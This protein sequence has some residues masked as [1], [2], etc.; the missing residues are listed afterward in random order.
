MKNEMI[1]VVPR[2]TL[3]DFINFRGYKQSVEVSPEFWKTAFQF[4]PRSAMEENPDFKQFIPYITLRYKDNIF[5][6]WRTKK[7]GESR[8]HHLYS[9][10]IGGH[11][12]PQDENLFTSQDEMIYEAAMRELQEEV[13]ISSAVE[14]KHIGYIN[15]DESKVGQV[16]FGIVYEAWLSSPDVEI[17]E[18]ALGRGEWV[19]INKLKDD[20]EYETWSQF[21]IDSF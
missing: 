12:N 14:L 21:I 1:L 7:A 8:L 10:G 20:V 11:I 9:V 6:Y 17:N 2:Q 18:N 5:R 16:H 19:P 15:D 4:K 13:K 3:G